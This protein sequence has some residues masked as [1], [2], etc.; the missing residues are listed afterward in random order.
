M[1]LRYLEYNTDVRLCQFFGCSGNQLYNYVGIGIRMSPPKGTVPKIP[2][3]IPTTRSSRQILQKQVPAKSSK[4]GSRRKVQYQ[5]YQ[6]KYQLPS[7]GAGNLQIPA[8]QPVLVKISTPAPSS[9]Y[10][11]YLP[12][13]SDSLF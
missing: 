8:R 9:T 1:L 7:A 10:H 2:T 3:K 12:L 11:T 6:P 5:K 13:H 4:L